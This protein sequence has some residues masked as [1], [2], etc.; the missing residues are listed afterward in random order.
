M[1]Y[2]F[3]FESLKNVIEVTRKKYDEYSKEPYYRIT[4]LFK[5]KYKISLMWGLRIFG[6]KENPN[7][8]ALLD[9]NGNIVTSLL[10][11]PNKAII[12][13]LSDKEVLSYIEK[14]SEL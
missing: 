4:I 6:D 5:N 12:N 9:K 7:E 3:N 1:N 10:K 8:I 14:A 11:Q 13:Y 2:N